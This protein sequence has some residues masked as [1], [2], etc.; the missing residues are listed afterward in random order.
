M[1]KECS[2]AQTSRRSSRSRGRRQPRTVHKSATTCL[3][4]SVHRSRTRLLVL[5]LALLA[6]VVVSALL[7]QAGM[8]RLEGK[9]RTFLE[10]LEWSAESLSTTGYGYDSHWTHP[11]M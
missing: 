2:R 11:A 9:S 6:F 7:Y 5:L 3:T 1:S 8:A 4:V 10:A